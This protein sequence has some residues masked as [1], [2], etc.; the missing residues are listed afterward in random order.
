MAR[1]LLSLVDDRAYVFV[2]EGYKPIQV[3]AF[4]R[5]QRLQ[6]VRIG[7]AHVPNKMSTIEEF[8]AV[9]LRP[10]QS[11]SAEVVIPAQNT[12]RYWLA[13]QVFSHDV[14]GWS[15]SAIRPS[16]PLRVP[17]AAVAFDDRGP[18]FNLKSIEPSISLRI[19]FAV[20]SLTYPSSVIAG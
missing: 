19:V 14:S 9:E 2:P 5:S 7:G 8:S 6:V 12:S 3:T 11:Q 10:N 4:R 1:R 17:A 15:Q 13:V 16:A 20:D 18:G